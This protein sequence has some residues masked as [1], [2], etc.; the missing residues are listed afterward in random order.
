MD[1]NI[2]ARCGVEAPH[3]FDPG[4]ANATP[5]YKPDDDQRCECG[6]VTW[7][8]QADVARSVDVWQWGTEAEVRVR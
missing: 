1:C 3:V 4:P 8:E 5:P 6:V 2:S 7:K